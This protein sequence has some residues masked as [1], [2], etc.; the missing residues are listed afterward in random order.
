MSDKIT[1]DLGS[2]VVGSTVPADIAAPIPLPATRR[3][4][5]VPAAEVAAGMAA[6]IIGNSVLNGGGGAMLTLV[7]VAFLAAGGIGLAF[8]AM[9]RRSPDI[10]FT[11]AA[12]WL[13]LMVLLAA[14]VS[15]LPLSEGR[16]PANAL[17][18]QSLLP[19][20]VFSAHPLGTDTQGLDV[21]SGLLYGAR[22]S[23][24]VAVGGIVIGSLIGGA[25]GLFAGYR[26]R[27]TDAV[28]SFVTDVVLS[29]PALILL[30][31][32][33]TVL[34]PNV[35][36]VTIALGVLAVPSYI[37]L[38]RANTIKVVSRDFVV[39]ARTLGA[40]DRRIMLREVLPNV[41]PS[42]F[43]YSFVVVGFLIVAEAS[44]S[45]LGL[46][47]QRPN[48]TWGNLIAQGEPYL[49]QHPSLVMAPSVLLFLTVVSMNYVGQRLQKK[50]GL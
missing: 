44:L 23:L 48:P 11:L 22:V 15:L 2:L 25:L 7:G 21:L 31:A 3:T 5:A 16:D 26:G 43:A 32:L 12:G 34:K 29:F 17:E 36:N 10:A 30:L 6:C 13:G 46:G 1:A 9:G 41:A 4:V 39:A 27:R 24:T 35:V 20:H 33:V 37:R 50:W 49:D 40:T 42:I 19:P 47:I 14:L 18:V 38:A 8:R 28:I 45:F